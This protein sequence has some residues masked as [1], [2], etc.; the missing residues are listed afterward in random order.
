METKLL[1]NWTED[2][3]LFGFPNLTVAIRPGCQWSWLSFIYLNFYLLADCLEELY[4]CRLLGLTIIYSRLRIKE[5]LLRL[6]FPLLFEILL[7]VLMFMIELLWLLFSPEQH[8]RS[9][10]VILDSFFRFR[11]DSSEFT[12]MCGLWL[13]I[14][15]ESVDNIFFLL[16][17]LIL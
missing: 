4:F 9:L 10:I 17:V 1:V 8:S 12:E 11:F 13:K 15:T 3:L 2:C 16:V 6:H 5:L 7:F 14:L